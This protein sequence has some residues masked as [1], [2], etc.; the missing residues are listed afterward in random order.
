MPSFEGFQQTTLDFIGGLSKNN[1]KTW[2]DAHRADYDAHYIGV[3]KDFILA[4]QGP[5]ARLSPDLVA[6][7]KVNGSIFR[8]NRDVRFSKDKRPYKDHLDL[9]FWQGQRKGAISGLFFRLTADELI[10]GAGAHGFDKE[11]LA[12]YRTAIAETDAAGD[13]LAI[14]KQMA[15]NDLPLAGAHYARL[16]R[17]FSTDDPEIERLLKF[18]ALHAAYYLP[19]P[20]QLAKAEFVN[21]C[22]DKWKDVMPLH[23]WLVRMDG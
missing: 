23:E 22:I 19:H 17:G 5:L 15:K 21:F 7:P 9:W 20:K 11:R 16:P 6:E 12:K 14:E 10:L 18:N 2:F 4:L 1:S 8:I 3:A 13:L